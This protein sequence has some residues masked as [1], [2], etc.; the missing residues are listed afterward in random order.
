MAKQLLK[1]RLLELFLQCVE[2]RHPQYRCVKQCIDDGEGWNRW[3]APPVAK[4]PEGLRDSIDADGVLFKL[5]KSL[6]LLGSALKIL[7][8]AQLGRRQ[9]FGWLTYLK[10]RSLRSEVDRFSTLDVFFLAMIRT[11]FSRS[12]ARV[13]AKSSMLIAIISRSASR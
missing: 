3:V 12:C 11:F 1:L 2:A 8:K 10:D 4:F 6:F 5:M 9:F 13:C 7:E